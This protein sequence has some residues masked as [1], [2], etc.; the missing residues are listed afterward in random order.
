MMLE[1]AAALRLDFCADCDGI[2][3]VYNQRERIRIRV[4]DGDE[5]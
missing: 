2:P 3:G 1:S 5:S 4:A